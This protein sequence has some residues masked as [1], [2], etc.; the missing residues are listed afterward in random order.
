[1][2][3]VQRSTEKLVL[4]TR[5]HNPGNKRPPVQPSTENDTGTRTRRGSRPWL[6]EGGTGVRGEH[7]VGAL[8]TDSHVLPC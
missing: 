2:T 7:G 8:P 4:N 6:V 5:L 1:M 3:L